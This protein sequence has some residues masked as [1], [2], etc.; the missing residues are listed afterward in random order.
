MAAVRDPST[1]PEVRGEVVIVKLDVGEKEDA[2]NVCLFPLQ[3]SR[4]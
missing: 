1:M 2:K 4:S 3:V